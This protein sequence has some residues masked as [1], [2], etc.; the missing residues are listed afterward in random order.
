MSAQKFPAMENDELVDAPEGEDLTV[1]TD[2]LSGVPKRADTSAVGDEEVA[3]GEF[4]DTLSVAS[5][6]LELNIVEKTSEEIAFPLI[7]ISNI[8]VLTSNSVHTP[9]SPY[10]TLLISLTHIGTL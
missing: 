1:A 9:S 4:S 6:E 5:E 2:G 10:T 3:D 8:N 7:G